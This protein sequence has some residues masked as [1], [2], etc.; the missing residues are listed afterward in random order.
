MTEIVITAKLANVNPYDQPAVEQVKLDT[1][2][3]LS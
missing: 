1:K 2:K 3:L